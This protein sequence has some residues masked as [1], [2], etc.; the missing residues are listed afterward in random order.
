LIQSVLQDK[1]GTIWSGTSSGGI[2]RFD[3]RCF[4]TIDSRDGLAG[5]AV[6]SLCMDKS[7]Q[8]WAG[9]TGGVVRFRHK[10]KIPPS[11][12]ITQVLADEKT[13]TQLSERLNLHAGVR[14][15]AFDFHAIS[16]KTRPGRMKYFYQLV[17][18]DND[19]QG[20]TNEETAEYF[21]LKPGGYAFKV[22]AVDR[23]LNYSEIASLE[24]TLP[25]VWHQI[26][27]VRG[28]LAGVGL[29]F[30][31]AFGFVT[32]RW[33]AHRRQVL[34]YQRAAVQELQDANRVQMSLMP[35]SAPP[36]EGVE[37][38]GKCMPA[39]TVSGDFFD[40]LEGKRENEIALVV[41]DVTGKAMK[42]A[43]N[44][45]MADGVLRMAAKAQ[46]KLSPASLMAELNDVLRVSMEWGMNITMV[47]GLIDADAKTLTLAN[48][49]H[50]AYP[51]L[52]H[53]GEI[54]ICKTGGLPLGMR[55]GVEYGEEQYK[56]QNGDV[57][58]FMSDG[59][60]EAQACPRAKRRDSEEQYYSDS[61]RLEKT[62]LNFTQDMSAEAMVD[63]ILNDAIDFGG[64]K[65]QR[66]AKDNARLRLSDDMTVVVAKIL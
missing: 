1:E 27:W 32:W 43:M 33:T 40:Y 20:E 15:V 25:P 30:L 63:A 21:H 66:D 7:G 29:V 9:T 47:I 28:T 24:L 59:I 36:I 57:V 56:L 39:N 42:G 58:I 60:I 61:G 45:V 17:G 38:A 16:F 18:K 19:W 10:N 51:L 6:H 8:V 64:D 44:A 2:S 34:A 65:T 13:Y 3:G 50:H 12:T 48:A 22:Q 53:K 14:R 5:D 23:D 4:Q 41:A 11:V 52:L 49:A 35:T 26:G 54:Q 62:L 31:V 46:E 37:I 55:A